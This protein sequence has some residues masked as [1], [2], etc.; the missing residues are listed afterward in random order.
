MRV[1]DVFVEG[2]DAE[3]YL[4]ADIA[5]DAVGI[6]D[7]GG[8][9]LQNSEVQLQFLV[10]KKRMLELDFRSRSRSQTFDVC[11]RRLDSV[12]KPLPQRLQWKGRLLARSTWAS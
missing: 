12:A 5:R 8:M 3:E 11:V 10:R 1:F 6:A 4:T 2:I 7:Q 9:L